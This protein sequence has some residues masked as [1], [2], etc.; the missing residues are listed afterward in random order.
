MPF[1]PAEVPVKR[2]TSMIY[3][4]ALPLHFFPNQVDD[5]NHFRLSRLAV[6]DCIVNRAQLL[7]NRGDNLSMYPAACAED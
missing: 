1:V 3:L 6:I 7:S 2:R 5:L 4:Y